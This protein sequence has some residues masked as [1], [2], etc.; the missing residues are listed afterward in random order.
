[1]TEARFAAAVL[2]ERAQALPKLDEI[3]RTSIDHYAQI[4]SLYRQNRARQLQGKVT[5]PALN[6]DF[7]DD[8]AKAAGQ[9]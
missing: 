6:D 2:D 1:M 7:Y 9:L 3:E 5:S 8:P 4:R